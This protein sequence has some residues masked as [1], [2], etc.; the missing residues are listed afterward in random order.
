MPKTYAVIVMDHGIKYIYLHF[1]SNGLWTGG[2]YRW[3]KIAYLDY[4]I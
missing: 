3:H 2:A 4:V 1:K